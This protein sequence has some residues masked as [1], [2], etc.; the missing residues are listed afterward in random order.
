[1]DRLDITGA[2]LRTARKT[3]NRF[4]GEQ[5]RKVFVVKNTSF[6]RAR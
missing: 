6:V 2:K 5:G 1:M 3:I 4:F